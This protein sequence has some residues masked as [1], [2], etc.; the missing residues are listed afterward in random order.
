M[1]TGPENRTDTR[2]W[3][4]KKRLREVERVNTVDAQIRKQ[5]LLPTI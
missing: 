3:G 4:D 2:E 5:T 1:T